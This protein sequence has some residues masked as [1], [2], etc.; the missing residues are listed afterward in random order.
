VLK[1]SA[2]QRLDLEIGYREYGRRTWQIQEQPHFTDPIPGTELGNHRLLS[3]ASRFSDLDF[4]AANHLRTIGL[5]ALA[6]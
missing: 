2:G 4:T 1:I 6:Q 5:A 3:I